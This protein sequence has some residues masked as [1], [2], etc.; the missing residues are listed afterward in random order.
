[1]SSRLRDAYA[2]V[3]GVKCKGLCHDTC[4]T[5]PV[6]PRELRVLRHATG[7]DLTTERMGVSNLL[8]ERGG[9]VDRCPLLGLDNRC[10]AHEVRP[11]VCRLYGVADHPRMR[12]PWGCEPEAPISN[13][14]AQRLMRLIGLL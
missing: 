3:P 10:T 14:A 12:C 11:L 4:N 1:M 9:S 2:Q 7:R 13:E 6:A 8:T 5:I